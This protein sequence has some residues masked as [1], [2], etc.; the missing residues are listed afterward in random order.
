MMTG[1]TSFQFYILVDHHYWK[2]GPTFVDMS[3]V[4][5]IFADRSVNGLEAVQR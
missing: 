5:N 1:P 3:E 2:F 4:F